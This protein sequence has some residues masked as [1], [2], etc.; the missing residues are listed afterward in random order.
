MKAGDS[1]SGRMVI[2]S[3]DGE[4]KDRRSLVLGSSHSGWVFNLGQRL[5]KFYDG[6]G[7][8]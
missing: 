7:R 4:F 5:G 6:V 1:C 3:D 2:R 8:R